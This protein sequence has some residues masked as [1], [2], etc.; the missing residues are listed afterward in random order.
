MAL[1]LSGTFAMAQ[2]KATSAI[3]PE[4][5]KAQIME[6]NAEI[7]NR[8]QLERMKKELNLTD[9]QVTKIKALQDKKLQEVKAQRIKMQEVK[10]ENEETRKTVKNDMDNEL[11]KI[12]TPEQ[13]TKWDTNRK[14]REAKIKERSS[15]M[16]IEAVQK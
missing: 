12:L 2:E 15:K 8:S 7:R 3:S 13:Y 9:D 1:A 14:E 6:K 5:K 16:S 11:K 10:K 4:Q